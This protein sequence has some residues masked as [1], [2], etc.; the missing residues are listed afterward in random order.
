MNYGFF[1]P[2]L[3]SVVLRK[4]LSLLVYIDILGYCTILGGGSGGQAS[5]IAFLTSEQGTEPSKPQF[6]HL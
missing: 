2:Y 4:I 6:P 5:L 1:K 3:I